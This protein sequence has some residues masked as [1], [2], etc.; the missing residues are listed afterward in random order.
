MAAET[1]ESP[2][3]QLLTYKGRRIDVG[4]WL[5]RHPGGGE[6][7]RY[8][9]GTD[10][11]CALH[12]FHDMRH[13]G[14]QKMLT[15]MDR[16]PDP[17]RPLS[18]FDKDY[19]ELE[20]LFNERGWFTPSNAYFI[21]RSCTV[22]AIFA[23]SLLVSASWLKGLLF[24]LFIQQAAFMAHDTCHHSAFPKIRERVS[25]LFGTVFFGFNYKKWTWQHNHHHAINGRPLDDP[26]LNNMPQLLYDF[27]EVE[28]FERKRRPLKTADKLMMGYQ[29]IWLLPVLLLYGR[30]NA[31]KGEIKQARRK[32][33]TWYL[34]GLALH[35]ALWAIPIAQGYPNLLRHTLIFVPLAL[36]VSGILHVQLILSHGYRPRFFAEEQAAIGMRLQIIS[37]Q[38]ISTSWLDGWF[39]GGLDLHIEHH[40]FPRLPRHNLRKIQ[41]YVQELCKKHGLTYNSDPFLKSIW[42]F[43]VWLA[44][45]GAPLRAELAAARAGDAGGT[46]GTVN[47]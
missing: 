40:L 47:S 19:L 18:E 28:N 5:E 27:R 23:A 9:L 33:E 6:V 8:F 37:N 4:S 31:I 36:A 39:H 11:T 17:E 14:I 16:G 29:H 30:P 45:Q 34:W 38:N 42:D 21:F 12:M 25:F 43:L 32:Q 46:G 35:L 22:L 13:K 15:K 10:A 7:L 44:R 26:Q 41:P 3:P 1:G 2:T 24:G 20:Q